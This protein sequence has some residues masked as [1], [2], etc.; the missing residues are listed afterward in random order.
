M[1]TK[2]RAHLSPTIPDN[3]K[4]GGQSSAVFAAQAGDFMKPVSRGNTGVMGKIPGLWENPWDPELFGNR[5]S[6]L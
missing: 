5:V 3:V 2:V 1:N 6:L 4:W